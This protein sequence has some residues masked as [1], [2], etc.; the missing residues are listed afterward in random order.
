MEGGESS[1]K[2]LRKDVDPMQERVIALA[3]S[4]VNMANKI[5]KMNSLLMKTLQNQ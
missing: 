4:V 1:Q 2:C 3:K 5:L